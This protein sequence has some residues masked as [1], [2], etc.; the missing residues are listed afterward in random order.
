MKTIPIS[1]EL[2]SLALEASLQAF[3]PQE[4]LLQARTRLQNKME[5]L[6]S[7][8]ACRNTENRAIG[9]DMAVAAYD[10]CY[11]KHTLRF[12]FTFFQPRGAWE[13]QGFRWV[14]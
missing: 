3:S 5:Q 6:G 13:I 12:H 4:L 7:F 2:S 10:L 14:A 1:I 11:E 9:Q 8:V